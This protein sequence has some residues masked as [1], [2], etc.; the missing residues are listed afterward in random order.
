[1]E[2]VSSSHFDGPCLPADDEESVN[3]EA[4]IAN[5]NLSTAGVELGSNNNHDNSTDLSLT[6]PSQSRNDER[7]RTTPM[8]GP[9]EKLGR[10]L[11]VDNAPSDLKRMEAGN[12]RAGNT[13]RSS[14]TFC[15][16]PL[17][18]EH[19]S[20]VLEGGRMEKT[21]EKAA[22]VVDADS[23]HFR[24]RL[25]TSLNVFANASPHPNQPGGLPGAYAHPGTA[26]FSSSFVD[27]PG[28]NTS[29]AALREGVPVLWEN[30][31]TQDGLAVAMPV[32]E[33]T[34]EAQPMD[35]PRKRREKSSHGK[36]FLACLC[37]LAIVAAG[38]TGILMAS[39]WNPSSSEERGADLDM[40]NNNNNEST[41][42]PTQGGDDLLLLSLL[43]EPTTKLILRD[44]LGIS[45]QSKAFQWLLNDPNITTYSDD[46]LQ[47]R[48]AVAT[49][50][51]STGGEEW[52]EQGG[53]TTT[54][55]LDKGPPGG[56]GG[57]PPPPKGGPGRFLQQNAS[58]PPSQNNTNITQPPPQGPPPPGG[59]PKASVEKVNITSAEWLSY[60]T[61]ECEWFSLAALSDK[62]PCNEDGSFRHLFLK[63]NNL[64]GSLPEELMMMT[65]LEYLKLG[66]DNI[67]STLTTQIGQM[68]KLTQLRVF[69]HALTGTIPSEVGLLSN[70]L[71]AISILDN[72]MT[73]SLPEQIWQLS[74]LDTLMISRNSFS[75]SIASGIG[76]RMPNL[77]T[78]MADRNQLSGVIP[79]SI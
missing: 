76:Y 67:G 38:L 63:S 78:L 58:L 14:S 40:Y 13:R 9:S 4:V 79:S 73:G 62:E 43:P 15:L 25:T 18:G 28:Y 12:T 57:A 50:Y 27:N 36:E 54:V 70:R 65:S 44:E 66:R 1:M 60:E 72:Q 77:E 34:A 29:S 45:P 31:F 47:Q 3:E 24:E 22:S 48:F 10:I 26:P 30:S 59:P 64:A 71:E 16:N 17:L 42:V 2:V 7:R 52:T 53:G 39:K 11:V 19:E 74:R 55:T 23:L 75:G 5:E 6:N 49:L 21:K 35:P 68:T 51:Y 20:V 69:S 56:P 33:P 8:P 61:P 37:V 41:A 46:R 32:T